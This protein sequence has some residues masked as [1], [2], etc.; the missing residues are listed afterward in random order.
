MPLA[1]IASPSRTSTVTLSC[2]RG[3][4]LG[5]LGEVLGARRSWR[6]S[7]AGRGRGWPPRSRSRAVSTAPASS[8]GASTVSDSERRLVVVL[9]GVALE[10][11]EAVG[12]EDRAGDDRLGRRR[13]R[14]RRRAAP[15]PARSASSFAASPATS[16]ARTR[17]FSTSKS[18]RSPEPDHQQP[19]RA[20]RVEPGHRFEGALGVARAGRARRPRRAASRPRRGRRRRAPRRRPAV[21]LSHI[22]LHAER[23]SNEAGSAAGVGYR[24]AG[25]GARDRGP[26]AIGEE[27]PADVQL[28]DPWYRAHPGRQDGRRPRLARSARARRHRDRG[29][30][31]ALRR[32][33]R[34]GPAGHLRPGPAG[35]PGP[36]PLAPGP[37]QGR[38]PEGGP[39]GDRQQGLRLGHADARPRRP[40]DPRRRP[41][42]SPSPAA[43]SR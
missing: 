26:A 10:V 25:R 41:R 16:A 7:P 37:D 30:A 32:R 11:G 18:S 8:A 34:A 36:D 35:R 2:A 29:R 31:G 1:R 40:G 6:A 22:D 3:D 5:A 43:W 21:T 19:L 9:V 38:H 13:P 27:R 28:S 39:L 20:A 23:E 24:P 14:P 4:L 42:R 15:R 33:R 12:A 17:S